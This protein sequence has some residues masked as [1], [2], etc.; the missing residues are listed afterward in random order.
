MVIILIG[1]GDNEEDKTYSLCKKVW[2]IYLSTVNTGDVLFFW[3]STRINQDED[4]ILEGNHL[5]FRDDILQNVSEEEL[6]RPLQKD[7]FSDW[8][9]LHNLS[10]KERLKKSYKWILEN[11]SE[12]YNFI[13]NTTAT[14]IHIISVLRGLCTILPKTGFQGGFPGVLEN[15]FHQPRFMFTSGSNTLLSFDLVAK[16]LDEDLSIDNLK[17]PDDVWISMKLIEIKKILLPRYDIERKVEDIYPDKLDISN[18]IDN[19]ITKGH[20]HFRVKSEGTREL[21]DH[22]LLMEI[23]KKIH[24]GAKP[25]VENF[26]KLVNNVENFALN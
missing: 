12:N 16:I 15:F 13:F 5:F 25:S 8:S 26:M 11:Y 6:S 22:I 1:I 3:V 21:T 17:V 9:D 14:S 23:Y 7:R 20:F 10:R 2:E 18:E 4:V 24:L 19:A